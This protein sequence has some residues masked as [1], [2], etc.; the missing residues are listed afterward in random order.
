MNAPIDPKALAAASLDDKYTHDSGTAFMTGTQALVR[1]PML[2]RK[3]DLAAG[4]NTAGFISGYRGSPVGSYDQALNRA[5]AH[6]KAHHIVFQPGVN[7]DL[8]ATSIW[9]TQQVN[10][11][12]GARYDGVFGIWYG[13]GPGVDRCG[14]VFKHANMA[15]TS[16]WG[17]V[18][19]LA[20]D[21]HGAKSSTT[22][23][24][25]EQIL[26]ACSTPVFY[27]AS[28]QD[29]L[30]YGVHGI[31][32][33]RFASLWSGI[34]CVTDVIESGATVD[35]SP[36]RV[37]PVI[38]TDV[39]LPEGGLAIRFNYIDFVGEEDRLLNHKLPA[40][41]AYVRANGLNR[42]LWR[43]LA[44]TRPVLGIASAGKAYAD[45]RQ[46]LAD[47]GIDEALAA[48]LGIRLFKIGV[49]WPLEATGARAV[50]Q[51]LAEV[52]V[53]E[54]KRPLIESQLKEALY[55]L[56]DAPRI[57]GKTDP[58]GRTLLPLHGELSPSIIARALAARLAPLAP[59]ALRERLA[60]RVAFLDAR[61][62]AAARTLP[63]AVRTPYFCSGCPHNT[64]TRVPQGS[65]ALAGIGCHY[66]AQWM[67]RETATFT[68]MGAEG[69]TWAGAAHFTDEKHVFVN[70]GDGTYFHSG[71]L[72][73]RA[74]VASKVNATY[75]V[76]FN[77]AVAMTGGQRHDG[78]LNPWL[79]SQ[80]LHAEGVTP[81]RV[82]TDEPDKYPAGTAWA[83]G[84]TVHHRSEL[85]AVQRALREMPGISAVIYDQTCAS[86][87][88]RRRKIGQF[89]DPAKRAFINDAVC[90]GCG[91]CSAKSNCISVEPHETEFGRKRRINQSS[92]NKDYSCV[93][94]F[95]PSF[96]TVEGGGLRKP[97][98]P[99][100]AATA[101][102]GA[103]ATVLPAFPAPAVPEVATPYNLLVTGIGGTGVITIGQIVAVAAHLEGK[104][105]R[106]LDMSGLAQKGGQVTSHVQIAAHADDLHTTRV[107]IAA[108]DLVVGADLVVTGGKDVLSRIGT[109][110]TR[111]LVNGTLSP[112]A[113]FVK[114]P[115]WTMPG[116]ALEQALVGAA[117]RDA[118]TVI[119]AGRIATALMGDAIATNMFLLGHAFQQGRI[120]VGEAALMRAIELNG[121]SIDFNKRAFDWGRYAAVDAAAVARIAT[122]AQVV[123]FAPRGG[124]DAGAPRSLDELVALRVEALT[125]YQNAGYAQRY[126]AFVDTV[127]RAEADRV[128]G[129][130]FTEAVARG[131]HKLMAYKDEY[132]VAR[133]HADPAFAQM[134]H[135][136]FEGD[137][138]LR[139]HLAPPLLARRDAN[140]E[141][142]KRDYGPWM[143][144]A[145]RVL[146]RFKGLRGTPFDPFGRTEERR[147]ERALIDEYRAL[148][149]DLLPTLSKAR[150]AEA[151]AIAAFPDD[152]RGFG[153]VK[154]R[155]L[156]AAR[157]TL[158]QRLAAYRAPAAAAPG[159]RAA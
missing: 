78:P 133:L 113:D 142:I 48:E 97:A 41:R 49:T 24:Q 75:K 30:D 89:P 2:Q 109:G 77:D 81:I 27:P 44:G 51:G 148:V 57:T 96:V 101:Q 150:L 5:K 106:V 146:A 35:L 74:A 123:A 126:A 23:H 155:H 20:G 114:D 134:L 158:A 128:G 37:T 93:T 141:L 116:D 50:A 73:I 131:L 22:A 129:T 40:V 8:A 18:L 72:A 56:P 107:G 90:E 152:I 76:L 65:R 139:F 4:R 59:P 17:G 130:A 13:K 125:A 26:L 88:R 54:E 111:V 136:Q 19:A 79:I 115:N 154:A 66:M 3:R 108:A 52:F 95:C 6:L 103:Q 144:G 83:P 105:A 147:T 121:V 119:P 62:G 71:L 36:Q 68:H 42:V 32:L 117:G 14:D 11:F 87:K 31:A 138:R 156:A 64:S 21:D 118:V 151:I 29:I 67:D 122:P 149:T 10:L 94:G 9:G 132:E 39:P 12:Q 15:G 34:K 120:P 58:E 140:G 61:E 135:A 25:S 86:E 143:L 99:Q 104:A 137:W 47:L 70:L 98:T 38:P 1:L 159:A 80:Q 53:V 85:D 112:T 28:V 7:E 127:R 55:G 145:M 43:E 60:A 92:C 84:V 124:R 157:T 16:P 82:V 46:A 91:D 45:L 69:A 153:H 110:R 102:A 33:S 63:V 100:V